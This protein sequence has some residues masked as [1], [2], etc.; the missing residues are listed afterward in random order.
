MTSWQAVSRGNLP[1]VPGGRASEDECWQDRVK[2]VRTAWGPTRLRGAHEG[3]TKRQRTLMFVHWLV[4]ETEGSAK[5]PSG[6][7]C[8]R[9]RMRFLPIPWRN[10]APRDDGSRRE[11]RNRHSRQARRVSV[12]LRRAGRAGWKG[13]AASFRLCYRNFGDLCDSRIQVLF[14]YHRCIPKLPYHD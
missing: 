14:R 7:R 13:L 9:R 11:R 2:N 5:G 6:S 10:G 12:P 1:E 3:R 8:L 4:A